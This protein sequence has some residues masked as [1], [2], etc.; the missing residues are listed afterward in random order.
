MKLTF[1]NNFILRWNESCKGSSISKMYIFE[2]A[3]T[4]EYLK[5]TWTNEKIFPIL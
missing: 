5:R 1:G 4:L 2:S 3:N